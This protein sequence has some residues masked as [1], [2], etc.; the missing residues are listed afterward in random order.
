M[1]FYTDESGGSSSRRRAKSDQPGGERQPADG[2]GLQND[3]FGL[4]VVHTLFLLALAAGYVCAVF[5]L[6]AK[7][8]PLDGSDSI[9]PTPADVTARFAGNINFTRLAAAIDGSMRAH[10]FEM[11][12]DERRIFEQERKANPAFEVK[13]MNI[14]RSIRQSR[15]LDARFKRLQD[16][17]L[18]VRDDLAAGVAPS[19]DRKHRFDDLKPAIAE[20]CTAGCHEKDAEEPPPAAG[21]FLDQWDAFAR[22]CRPDT[23]MSWQQIL[24][25]S[26][27][28]LIG[29]A[30]M[31]ILI[32]ALFRQ[33]MMNAGIK[34]L[35]M[36]LSFLM[37]LCDIA[38]WFLVKATG[39]DLVSFFVMLAGLT[40]TGCLTVMIG[41]PILEMWLRRR[42]QPAPGAAPAAPK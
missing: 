20:R 29:I 22:L 6:V 19:D 13:E 11:T 30:T 40:Q 14:P 24:E 7:Y 10:A 9:L 3:S 5:N 12:A 42:P 34:N 8:G 28:H 21:L 36:A 1:G 27:F 32:C 26:H 25:L 41:Y 33:T 15:P 23:G 16:L 31:L 2:R 4:R 38:G 37:L 18:D 39:W 35:V 17:S